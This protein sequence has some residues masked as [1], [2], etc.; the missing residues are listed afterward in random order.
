MSTAGWNSLKDR[1]R[2]SWA[3]FAGY[4]STRREGPPWT[5]VNQA[6]TLE[7]AVLSSPAPH[8]PQSALKRR[9]PESKAFTEHSAGY[10]GSNTLL[11]ANQPQKGHRDVG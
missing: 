10:P 11:S 6:S 3:K 1:K 2:E 9:L 7:S 5:T 8:M 4:S